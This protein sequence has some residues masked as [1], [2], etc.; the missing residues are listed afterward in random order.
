MA[1]V[2]R[3]AHFFGCA[4]VHSCAR[5]WASAGMSETC[6]GHAFSNTA[7]GDLLTELHA[8]TTCGYE[9]PATALLMNCGPIVGV[10]SSSSMRVSSGSGKTGQIAASAVCP[11]EL[12][13]LILSFLIFV[14]LC[15]IPLSGGE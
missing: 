8:Q 15:N 11:I 10:G 5:R 12:R 13:L 2:D 6:E 1:L 9:I 3:F 4:V 14:S 7:F